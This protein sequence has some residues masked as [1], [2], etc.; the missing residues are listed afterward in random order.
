MKEDPGPRQ[1][2]PPTEDHET[3]VLAIR[4]EKLLDKALKARW[5][6]WEEDVVTLRAAVNE[7]RRFRTVLSEGMG[8]AFRLGAEY[9]KKEELLEKLERQVIEASE[10]LAREAWGPRS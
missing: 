6:G 8:E 7:V 2:G 9:G 4:L 10:R 3:P 5:S 1:S